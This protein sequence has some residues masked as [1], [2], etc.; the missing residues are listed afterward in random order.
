[1][2]ARPDGFDQALMDGSRLLARCDVLSNGVPV[3]TGIPIAAGSVSLSRSGSSRRSCDVVIAS[4]ALEPDDAA[5]LLS[6]Y[7]SEIR[8]WAGVVLPTNQEHLICVGTF[9]I[10]EV[11]ASRPSNGVRV[12]GYDRMKLVEQA[13]FLWPRAMPEGG[14]A[15]RISTLLIEAVPW[16]GLLSV[17]TADYPS[18]LVT[19]DQ[20]RAGAVKDMA[21]SL[22]GEV[23]ADPFG[24][25]V[26]QPIPDPAG[27]PDWSLG[28]GRA[29]AGV[30]RSQS[31]DGVYNAVKATSSMPGL[32]D[33]VAAVVTDDNPYSPTFYGGV[34]QLTGR[35]FGASPLFYASPLIGTDSQA[36]SAAS[37]LLRDRVGLQRSLSIASVV[38]P[39]LEPGD[40]VSVIIDGQ[41]Q[42]HIAE[43]WTLTLGG[44]GG[45]MTIETRSTSYQE[46][47]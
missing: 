31:R 39:A 9:P 36:V 35:S 27:D 47:A 3:A 44:S 25:F 32:A 4:D 33:P 38:Q 10:W 8:L 40:I 16:A 5:D 18:G 2:I 12:T 42:S 1:M 45:G 6:P 13:R 29:L 28:S 19:Y 24:A 46:A 11:S 34:S 14:I 21:R 15:G 23:F 41:A 43:S 7:G 20:D 37:S 30:R 22:G 17:S 26:L